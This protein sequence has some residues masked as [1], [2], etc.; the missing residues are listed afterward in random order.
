MPGYVV[1]GS[2]TVKLV[3]VEGKLEV[4]RNATIRAET[5]RKV[6]VDGEA[7]FEGPVTLDCDFECKSMRVEGRGYGPGGDVNMKGNLVVHGRADLNASV[8]VAGEIVAEDLDV[9]GHLRSGS[10][11][12]KRLRVGGHLTVDGN[13]KAETVD[14]GG[15]MSVT[16]NVDLTGLRVGGHAKIGGGR[17]AGEIKVRGH[18][19][20]ERKLDFGQFQVYGYL[21]LPA[22]SNGES[23]SAMGKVEFE[24]DAT[25]REIE[26]SGVGKAKGDFAADNVKVNGK[27]DTSGSLRVS[28]KLEV[29]GAAE[30]KKNLEC[31][32]ISVGG[33]LVAESV[34]STGT[35][36][37]GGQLWTAQG[38]K[39]KTVLVGSGSRVNGPIVGETVEVGGGID[40]SGLWGL[41]T[42]WRTI[43]QMTRVG[44]VWGREVR[45]DRYSQVKRIYAEVVKMQAG[46][47]A[48][49]VNYTKEADVP[50]G[51]RVEKP[52][53]KVD[54]L[55]N[56][57]L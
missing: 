36:D 3:K 49:E 6:V 56:P 25:C 43:G 26:I 29:Y 7:H 48:D 10:L 5:G 24:G 14:V 45:I 31:E 2:S 32:T 54:K 8:R 46:S 52:P 33:R 17:I 12:S 22:G 23:L 53:K 39:A 18:F 37:V 21:R 9:A 20:T 55:A 50:K 44:D 11:M 40:T 19:T 1:K 27:L 4:G 16:K 41:A 15:H 38:L 34:T 13:L 57:P 28:G 51:S 30:V 35:A 47:I 42:S